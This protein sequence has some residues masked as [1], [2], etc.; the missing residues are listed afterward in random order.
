M[1]FIIDRR[2]NGKNKSAVNRQ[3]FLRRYRNHIKKAVTDAVNRRSITDLEHGEKIN[4]PTKDIN[5]PVFQ[6]GQG[7]HREIV[8][9]GNKE[10]QQGDRFSR[11]QGGGGGGGSGEG[12]ASNSGEGEDEFSFSITKDE[13]LEFMF[14]GLE[15]PNLVRKEF[16]DMESVK[17]VRAGII[18]DGTPAKVNIV[19]SM[20]NAQARRRAMTSK[21]RRKLREL[22]AALEEELSKD[23]LL[24]SSVRIEELETAIAQLKQKIESVPFLDTY[25]LRY[26][27]FRQ[28]PQP[29]NQ[30]VMFCLM[31]V[32]GSMTQSH[33]DMAKRFFILLYLF[34]ERNYQKIEVVFIRHHTSATEVDEET[35]FYSRETGGTI[36]SS[37]IRLTQEVI[38]KRYSPSEWNIYVAQASDGD[39]WDDDSTNCSKILVN[40]LMPL[41]Q[42]FA[43]VE[44]TPHAHQ[45]LWEEYEG[46]RDKFQDRFAMEQIVSEADIYPVF[47]ELFRR[48]EA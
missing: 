47:R 32:S 29:S 10:F 26:N 5:E 33:K 28:E 15:L 22:K 25:D 9:P 27:H 11:P 16:K 17:Q 7:G 24:R 34:L 38:A 37:A 40:E 48:K 4:I 6:Q 35:F 45:S 46:V 36:V 13:F 44:I 18:K 39:N 14:D 41:L 8:S 19:R 43:Y 21:S 23:E 30:A 31:D 3:R 42:Y 1:S 2:L 20:R 12:K